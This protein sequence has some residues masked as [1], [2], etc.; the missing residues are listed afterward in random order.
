M[1]PL[2]EVERTE[3]EAFCRALRLRPRRDPTNDDRSLLR[4]AIR[5]EVL[6]AIERATRRDP[7]RPIARSASLLA[8]VRDEL[9]ASTV[10]AFTRVVERDAT[11]A[12]LDVGALRQ[13]EPSVASRVVRLALFNV[14]GTD[15][16]APWSM[17]DVRAVLDLADGRP[18]RR[19]DLSNGLL[20]ERGRVYLSLSSRPSPESRG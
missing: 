2:L 8:D 1:Q 9:A 20:A 4:N 11:G 14:L 7:R 15:A 10:A 19:R 12:R 17:A 13:L 6:P 3:V 18:G 5:H 16:V